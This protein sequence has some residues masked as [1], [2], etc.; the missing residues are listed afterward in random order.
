M[1]W[2]LLSIPGPTVGV[3]GLIP[4]PNQEKAKRQFARVLAWHFK[5]S[6]FAGVW[7]MTE[8]IM[9]GLLFNTAPSVA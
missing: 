9:L 5:P 8:R 1:T 4:E 7:R 2:W 3:A 6:R